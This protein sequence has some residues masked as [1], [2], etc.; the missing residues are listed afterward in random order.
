MG[1]IASFLWSVWFA[2]PRLLLTEQLI[3]KL[4]ENVVAHDTGVGVGLTF[5]MENR[6]GRLIDAVHL[7]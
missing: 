2:K 7:A 5:A 4:L 6:G 1:W 3:E